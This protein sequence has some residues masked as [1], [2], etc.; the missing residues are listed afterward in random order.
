MEV[1]EIPATSEVRRNSKWLRGFEFFDS[2]FLVRGS[3]DQLVQLAV[4]IIRT[5]NWLERDKFQRVRL[6]IGSMLFLTAFGI[7]DELEFVRRARQ[8]SNNP[9]EASIRVHELVDFASF[10]I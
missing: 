10:G 1:A 2:G 4:A 7:A 5:I 6:Q 3:S 8:Q 9:P